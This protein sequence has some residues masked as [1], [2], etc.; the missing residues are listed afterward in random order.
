MSRIV[1][2]I[3]NVFAVLP[4]PD[5]C[6]DC[7]LPLRYRLL[8]HEREKGGGSCTSPECRLL[9]FYRIIAHTGHP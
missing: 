1:L 7:F 3:I 9:V 4:P 6:G 8:R 5:L 2:V